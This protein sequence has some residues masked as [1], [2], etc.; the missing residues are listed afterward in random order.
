MDNLRIVSKSEAWDNGFDISGP[1][2]FL[3]DLGCTNAIMSYCDLDNVWRFDVA[4]DDNGNSWQFVEENF[5]K[6]VEKA[7]LISEYMKSTTRFIRNGYPTA[8]VD[9]YGLLI[10]FGKSLVD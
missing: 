9:Y 2:G 5:H 4:V 8:K 6:A 3:V 1:V 10:I 7:N